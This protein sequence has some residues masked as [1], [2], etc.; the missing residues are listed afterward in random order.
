M[1]HFGKYVEECFSNFHSYKRALTRLSCSLTARPF[2]VCVPGDL[3]KAL[4]T[5]IIRFGGIGAPMSNQSESVDHSHG[6]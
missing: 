6:Y 1:T 2:K 3:E 5:S 4:K